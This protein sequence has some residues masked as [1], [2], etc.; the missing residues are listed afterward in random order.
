ME[1]GRKFM[2]YTISEPF[3]IMLMVLGILMVILNVLEIRFIVKGSK[4]KKLH[5]SQIYLSNLALSDVMFGVSI[6]LLSAV[7]EYTKNVSNRANWLRAMNLY[8]ILVGIRIT[9]TMSIFSLIA[10]T[11][12][13]LLGILK[14]FY[15]RK[16]ENKHCVCI[17]VLTW[18]VA[19]TMGS[20]N[21]V[22]MA[23]AS[24]HSIDMIFRRFI[25]SQNTTEVIQ[26]ATLDIYG[27]AYEFK[28]L[29]TEIVS[30]TKPYPDWLNNVLEKI[31]S[32]HNRFLKSPYGLR[33]M[34]QGD[35]EYSFIQ[36]TIYTTVFI[37]LSVYTL[38][39][40]RL[41]KS[42]L[43]IRGSAKTPE[44]VEN[45]QKTKEKKFVKLSIAIVLA[46]AF[47]WLPL[48]IHSTIFFYWGKYK[49]YD[50]TSEESYVMMPILLNSIIN[51]F[52]YFKM[53]S[54][55]GFCT[56]F[57]NRNRRLRAPSNVSNTTEF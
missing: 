13:R 39:W 36:V 10:L 32:T 53:M 44:I 34:E 9:F 48:A 6:I 12:D 7:S 49:G 56:K 8:L 35:F 1:E 20:L 55:V 27:Y 42:H 21:I 2:Y 50:V 23:T 41:R 30:L 31:N 28:I 5:K 24:H 52:L 3:N 25:D 38:I 54:K 18:V 51:P 16:I 29:R 33:S 37:L 26:H 17:C 22:L 43:F 14:P 45:V 15:H 46:F 40:Y 47:C 19:I 11:L 57:K 4:N